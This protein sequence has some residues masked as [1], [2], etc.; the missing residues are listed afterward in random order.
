MFF[1]SRHRPGGRE[2]G[3][4]ER[5]RNLYC[6]CHRFSVFVL[7][8]IEQWW[9]LSLNVIWPEYIKLCPTVFVF[10]SSLSCSFK[11][12]QY[13]Q[14]THW[15]LALWTSSIYAANIQL[16]NVLIA[17]R[18]NNKNEIRKLIISLRLRTK[19]VNGFPDVRISFVCFFLYFSSVVSL[20]NFQSRRHNVNVCDRRSSR[21]LFV[22]KWIKKRCVSVY[23]YA[24]PSY[25]THHSLTL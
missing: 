1:Y 24:H 17:D 7:T 19:G 20:S 23:N 4:R 18:K 2:H 16:W 15:W 6:H 10:F 11:W 9:A 8:N 3:E 12:V 25:L 22:N 5:E 21:N 13:I 14:N